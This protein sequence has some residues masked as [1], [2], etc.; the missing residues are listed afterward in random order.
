M[1]LFNHRLQEYIKNFGEEA[2]KKDRLRFTSDLHDSCGY[3]FTN[4]IAI[5]DAAISCGPMEEEK[6]NETFHLIQSQARE[7]LKKTRETLHMIREIRDPASGGI[8]TVYQMK[9]IFEEVTGIKVEIEIGNMKR[10]YGPAVNSVIA[11]TVQE[12]FTNSIRH[13]KA[14][15]I[16][17]HFWEFPRSLA[18][19]VTDNGGGARQVVMGIGLAGMEER[20]AE[21]GGS[22]SVSSPE[23]GGFRLKIEIPLESAFGKI[24][25]PASP[26]PAEVFPGTGDPRETIPEEVPGAGT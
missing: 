25:V 7:G 16:Q 23:D 13:G 1:L 24:P 19:T 4:I 18:M 17:I 2:I 3:V 22:L 15:R 12:A 20:L 26:E 11:R 14:S 21:L 8:D 9:N 5:S 6:L 10:N